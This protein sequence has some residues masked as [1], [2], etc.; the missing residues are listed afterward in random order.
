VRYWKKITKLTS[1]SPTGP[2]SIPEALWRGL[3]L[4]MTMHLATCYVA[5]CT[6]YFKKE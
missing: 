6:F 3:E 2:P 1:E 5:F 4:L